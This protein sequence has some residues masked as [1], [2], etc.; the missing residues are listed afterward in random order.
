ME[1]KKRVITLFFI[2]WRGGVRQRAKFSIIPHFPPF[3]QV[4]SVK[5][6]AQI[7][8]QNFGQFAHC[9]LPLKVL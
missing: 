5:K 9:T 1:K 2:W 7:F 8:T 4:K 3:C 6:S